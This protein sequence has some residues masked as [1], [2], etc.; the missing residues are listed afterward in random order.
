MGEGRVEMLIVFCR[1]VYDFRPRNAVEIRFI[2]RREARAAL[3][4]SMRDYITNA[5][6]FQYSLQ[7]PG[8]W[9]LRFLS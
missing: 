8:L 9:I 1:T 7:N 5:F 2:F 3:L 4:H 6:D